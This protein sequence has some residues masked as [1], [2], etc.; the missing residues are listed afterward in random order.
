M[1]NAKILELPEAIFASV[2]AIV[3]AVLARDVI[4]WRANKKKEFSDFMPERWDVRDLIVD[5]IAKTAFQRVLI[6]KTTNGGG[7]PHVGSNIYAKC[8]FEDYD[9][10]YFKSVKEDYS[11]VEADRHYER[12]VVDVARHKRVEIKTRE[13]PS[14]VL[15]DIYEAEG[16][17]V[18]YVYFLHQT[19]SEFYYMSI[20]IHREFVDRLTASDVLKASMTV[21]KIAQI[22]KTIK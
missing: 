3:T 15:K 9:P 2:S 1:K 14:G 10:A 4:R 8:L 16:V 5:I 12:L 13:L 6:F 22:Y 7:M 21:Q 20:A 17:A 19:K 18:S 11:R